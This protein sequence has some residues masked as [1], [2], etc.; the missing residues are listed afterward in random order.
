MFL[1]WVLPRL[2]SLSRREGDMFL[3]WSLPIPAILRRRH[4]PPV[5]APTSA[6]LRE[7]E[8]CSFFPQSRLLLTLEHKWEE[9]LRLFFGPCAF[10]FYLSFIS[11][12]FKPSKHLVWGPCPTNFL[13]SLK[14][15]HMKAGRAAGYRQ[16]V[17]GVGR[18]STYIGLFR[19]DWLHPGEFWAM[20]MGAWIR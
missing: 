19:K 5:S 12:P 17:A 15:L 1:P 16:T 8:T 13:R 14:V 18:S 20:K 10:D 2:A 7:E 11:L 6:N 4:A 9:D 3:L